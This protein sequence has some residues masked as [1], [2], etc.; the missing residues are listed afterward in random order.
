MRLS[1]YKPAKRYF[2]L[3]WSA[4][5]K[6]PVSSI[7]EAEIKIELRKIIERHGKQ[8]ARA[9]KA[10]LS[11]FYVWALKEGVA[12]TNP[13][14]ATHSLAQNPPRD[15]VLADDEIRAIWSSL[16]ADDFGRIVKLL[17][18]TACR[19]D[20]IGGLKWS[21]LVL[22]TGA[23]TLPPARTKSGRGHQLVLPPQAIAVLRECPR[24]AD[25]AFL[26]G[27]RGGAFCRWGWDKMRLDR[28]LA[29]AGH[30]FNEPWSLHDIRRT[31]RTRLAQIGVKPYIAEMVLGH[32]AHRTGTV[33]IYELY[34]YGPEI[35]EALARWADVLIRIINPPD[36]T[37]VTP[38]RATA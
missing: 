23:M 1:T 33:P 9:A 16:R 35:A 37:N 17:F 29:T 25:R 6:R 21:E 28:D 22:D 8:A 36:K 5:A 31:V 14:I 19:R 26:F 11:A 38:I 18:F 13:T 24:K 7:T 12:K 15:R 2:E 4:L 3:H 32:A 10:N 27:Q 20:E 30:K 34:N